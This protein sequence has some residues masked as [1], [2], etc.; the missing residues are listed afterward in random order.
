LDGFAGWYLH[1]IRVEQSWIER[2][3]QIT[4]SQILTQA[5]IEVRRAMITLKGLSNF[6][7]EAGAKVLDQDSDR[8]GMPRRLL[9]IAL[10]QDEPVILVEVQCPSTQK[11]AHLRVPPNMERC[12]QAVAWSFGFEALEKYMPEVEA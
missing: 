10:P 9:Q 7:A 3:E 5:N 8:A 12:S 6:L 1:G 11:I 2:P 4:V